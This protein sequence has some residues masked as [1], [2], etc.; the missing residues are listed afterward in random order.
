MSRA[1][2]GG[3][4]ERKIKNKF[5]TLLRNRD[6]FM[7][8]YWMPLKEKKGGFFFVYG[9]GGTGK[10]FIWKTLA[11]ALRSE[12]KIVLTVASS[13]IASLLLLGGRTSHSRFAIPLN[14]DED[15]TCNIKQGS[16]LADLLVRTSLI[17]WDEAPTM[18]KYYFEALDRTLHDV[19]HFKN[20]SNNDHPFG[21]KTIVFGRDFRQILPVIPKGSKQYIVNA[22]LNSSYLWDDCEVLKL[23]K[24][25]RLTIN[26]SDDN[27]D[28]LKSFSDWI[29]S[30]GDEKIG[31]HGD[32]Y[33][34][35][36]IP[37]DNLILDASDPI[38]AIVDAIYPELTT[39]VNNLQYFQQRA[40]LA[41]TLNMVEMINDYMVSLNKKES[42][43]FLSSDS[44]C[45]SDFGGSLLDQIHTPDFLN[46]IKCSATFH[47]S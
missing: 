26:N 34:V 43:I 17:I 39:N 16:S 24:N 22:T 2:I 13:G 10:T 42:M 35:V 44:T 18:N 20:P 4:W 14:L 6:K 27:I 33:G 47:V 5:N 32:G 30:I 21:G 38:A 46:C 29:L 9:Y 3:V 37:D 25:M 41:P 8:K 11:S 31:D 19:M 36:R 12:R 40:I 1:T 28:D 15:S 7:I 23:T 45:L